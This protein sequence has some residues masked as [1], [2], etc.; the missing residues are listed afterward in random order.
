MILT[1][2]G[3]TVK[4]LTDIQ[5]GK[6]KIDVD[7]CL[8]MST[9]LPPHVVSTP[10]DVSQLMQVIGEDVPLL[11]LA[12]A[13][14]SIIQRKCL[15]LEGDDDD[16]YRY[17]VSLEHSTSST[18]QVK[19]IKS[20][21]GGARYEIGD[22]VQFSIGSKSTAYGRIIG[23]TWAR[24]GKCKLDIQLLETGGEQE[25]VDCDMS[26]KMTVDES[27]LQG[28]VLMLGANDFVRLGYINGKKS[29]IFNRK[30]PSYE[31]QMG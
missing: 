19:S 8:L 23:I 2:C 24:Q 11:D 25:L 6:G 1:A 18:C 22:L 17:S 26:A 15:P 9:T 3:A 30:V 27:S 31:S 5:K 21:K 29:N 4:T 14:Q 7:C 13:H 20:A 16:D 28:N 10:L 12:W